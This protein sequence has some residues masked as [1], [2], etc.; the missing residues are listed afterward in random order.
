[1]LKLTKGKYYVGKAGP[2]RLDGRIK[3]HRDGV[4]KGSAWTS[5][6]KVER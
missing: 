6:F 1:M 4:G 3:E 2:G 5:L